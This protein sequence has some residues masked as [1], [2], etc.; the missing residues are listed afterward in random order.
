MNKYNLYGIAHEPLSRREERPPQAS[1]ERQSDAQ[2][3][4]P[5]REWLCDSQKAGR[6]GETMHN[7]AMHL[8]PPKRYANGFGISGQ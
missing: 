8:A 3:Q 2:P 6:I 5:R 1:P 7:S 4:Q